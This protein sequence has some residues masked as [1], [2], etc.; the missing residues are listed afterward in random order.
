MMF[1]HCIPDDVV[2]L[3]RNCFHGQNH[4]RLHEILGISCNV[5]FIGHYISDHFSI[6]KNPNK[7]QPDFDSIKSAKFILLKHIFRQKENCI[8]QY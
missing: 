2:I 7:Q 4:K 3:G 1:R 6:L 8:Q 5:W